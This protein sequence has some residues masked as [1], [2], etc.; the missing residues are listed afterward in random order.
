MSKKPIPK[1]SISKSSAKKN[2]NQN[3]SSSHAVKRRLRLDRIAVVVVPLILIVILIVLLCLNSCDLSENN[4]EESSTTAANTEMTTEDSTITDTTEAS[5]ADS[6]T[7]AVTQVIFPDGGIG[8]GNLV[9]INST[10][11]YTFPETEE[12]LLTVHD[13]QNSSYSVSDW[14]VC[15]E[16]ETLNQLNAMMSAYETETGYSNMEVYSGY[17]TEDEQETLYENG[18]SSFAGGNSDYHSGRTFNLKIKFTDGSSDYYNAEK[19]PDYSW[20]AEN[21]ASYGFVVRYPADKE[22]ITGEESRSYT[23]RYVGV[24]HA[25]YMSEQNLCLEEYVALLQDYTQDAPLQITVDDSIY[26]VFYVSESEATGGITLEDADSY[27]VSG[28]NIGGYI[29]SYTSSGNNAAAE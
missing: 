12:D 21:A 24:P 19:Y 4:N 16:T 28:D 29:I 23:F 10:Y 6:S 22:N 7:A 18:S 15:L 9:V 5:A 2:G 20:I 14:E 25:V 8:E 17:R 13:N 26:F 3:P 1:S 27:T 11:A